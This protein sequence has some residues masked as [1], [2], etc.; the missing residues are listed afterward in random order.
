[1]QW[2]KGK[3]ARHLRGG[4]ERKKEKKGMGIRGIDTMWAK[5]EG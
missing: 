2:P 3:Y 5:N 1:M 4:G